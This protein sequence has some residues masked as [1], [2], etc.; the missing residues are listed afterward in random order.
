[1]SN[2]K[3]C[4]SV[5]GAKSETI[6]KTL[7]TSILPKQTENVKSVLETAFNALLKES[8]SLRHGTISLSLFYRDGNISRFVVDRQV[9][10]LC[11]GGEA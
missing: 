9:S 10:F 6:N 1:M 5:Q 11:N 8:Q 4:P 7:D 3:N 2:K